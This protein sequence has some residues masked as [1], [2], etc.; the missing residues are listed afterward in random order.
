VPW[1]AA[2]AILVG[3]RDAGAGATQ[4]PKG[5]DDSAFAAKLK[6]GM[7]YGANDPRLPAGAAI[8]Y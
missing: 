4:L 5:G 7:R 3:P 2:A 8:G 1:G 6:P